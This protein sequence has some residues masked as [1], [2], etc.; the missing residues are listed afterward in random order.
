MSLFLR[1]RGKDLGIMYHLNVPHTLSLNTLVKRK[2]LSKAKAS[3]L[4]WIAF[5]EKE[6]KE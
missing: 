5:K 2:V 4:S 6:K 3:L 1:D